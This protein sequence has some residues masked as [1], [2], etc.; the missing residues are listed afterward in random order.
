MVK[1]NKEIKETL[2]QD[3]QNGL[4]KFEIMQKYNISSATY[5]RVIKQQKS[6]TQSIRSNNDE[7]EVEVEKEVEN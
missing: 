5:H 2:I 3:S 4:S 1:V 6:D 7:I